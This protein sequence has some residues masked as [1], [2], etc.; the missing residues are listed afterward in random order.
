MNLTYFAQDGSFGDAHNIEIIDTSDF[1]ENDWR[2]IWEASDNDKS[3]VAVEIVLKKI[4]NTIEK[5]K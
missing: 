4:T 2:K 5:E 3:S 1:N